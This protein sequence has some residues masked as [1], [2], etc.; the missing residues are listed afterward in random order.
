MLAVVCSWV[1][2]PPGIE[3]CAGSSW[4]WPAPGHSGAL[5]MLLTPLREAVST[6]MSL[7]GV[8]RPLSSEPPGSSWVLWSLPASSQGPLVYGPIRVSPLIF[9]CCHRFTSLLLFS[10]RPPSSLPSH[11]LFH[12][13]CGL[14]GRRDCSVGLACPLE[15]GSDGFLFSQSGLRMHRVV[16]HRVSLCTAPVLSACWICPSPGNR[17]LF[18][19]PLRTPPPSPPGRV[20]FSSVPMVASYTFISVLIMMVRSCVCLGSVDDEFPLSVYLYYPAIWGVVAVQKAFVQHVNERLYEWC[21]QMWKIIFTNRAK[22][23]YH[24]RCDRK[25]ITKLNLA[26]QLK[27]TDCS[28][29]LEYF[30]LLE[31]LA[32]QWNCAGCSVT[33]LS[34]CFKNKFSKHS[35][36]HLFALLYV[37]WQAWLCVCLCRTWLWI[38]FWL[39]LN[40]EFVFKVENFFPNLA[41]VY[42]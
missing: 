19:E 14:A 4:T 20:N 37:F 30:S 27:D 31:S 15:S 7:Q 24:V 3:G 11:S 17:S 36:S 35:Q 25:V 2:L 21:I 41:K 39:L 29:F 23:I 18:F 10:A 38:N 16:P 13:F 9:Q 40:I 42:S 33:P 28:S 1:L 34:S 12:D 32:V 26:L 6:S 22:L 8:R 5:G